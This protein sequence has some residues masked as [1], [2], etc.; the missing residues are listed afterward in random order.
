[1]PRAARAACSLVFV[2]RAA[3]VKVDRIHAA[4]DLTFLLG[5]Y[6]LIDRA[7]GI[8]AQGVITVATVWAGH[9]LM[10]ATWELDNRQISR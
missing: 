6:I 9:E 8:H 2:E 3:D 1:M 4:W 7:L 5:S 10:L